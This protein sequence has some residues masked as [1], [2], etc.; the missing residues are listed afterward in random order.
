LQEGIKA[1]NRTEFETQMILNHKNVIAF[2]FENK[3]LFANDIEYR[4]LEEL[5]RIIVKNLGINEGIRKGLVKITASNYEPLHNPRQL[6]ENIA[7]VLAIINRTSEPF[8]KA[9]FALVLVP[10]L[11]AFEDGNKRLGRLLANAI[12]IS[13]VGVGFSLRKTDAKQLSLAYL[14]FYEFNSMATIV[15]I[16]SNELGG[17]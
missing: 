17:K 9:L 16:L 11:Q 5:H 8:I 3:D 10:Y 7:N 6:K 2:I 12:L 13:S 15:K 14:A 1:S 4:A